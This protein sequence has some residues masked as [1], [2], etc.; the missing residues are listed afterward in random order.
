MTS[1]SDPDQR[2][3]VS[4]QSGHDASG[5]MT[6]SDWHSLSTDPDNEADLDY[7]LLEWEQFE[8]LDSADHLVFLPDDET[9][10][11]DAAF[12]VADEE[13]VIDLDTRR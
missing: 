6:E 2:E 12:V 7:R 3:A 1:D 8:T 13:S 5:H 4:D 11:A 9:A 10:V